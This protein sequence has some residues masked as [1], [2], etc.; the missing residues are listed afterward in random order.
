MKWE[1]KVVAQSDLAEF[2]AVL[3]GVGDEGWE[4]VSGNFSMGVPQRIAVGGGATV[5]RPGAPQWIAVL[6]RI[7]AG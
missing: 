2:I 7:K 6:K 5:D 4:A 3:N 1:H